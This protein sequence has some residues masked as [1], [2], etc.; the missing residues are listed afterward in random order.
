MCVAKDRKDKKKSDDY[1]YTKQV[2]PQGSEC[3]RNKIDIKKKETEFDALVHHGGAL[4]WRNK[5][6]DF[7]E[8]V[9]KI[10]EAIEKSHL[11]KKFF[12]YVCI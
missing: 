10:L 3:W 7:N 2:S 1:I 9:F 12:V 11:Q 4:F 8:T 5:F 6:R